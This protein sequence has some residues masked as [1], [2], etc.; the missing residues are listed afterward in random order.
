MPD[1][2]PASSF[3]DAPASSRTENRR[4]E[5]MDPVSFYVSC[6]PL[7]RHHL[8]TGRCGVSPLEGVMEDLARSFDFAQDDTFF[9]SFRMTRFYTEPGLQSGEGVPLIAQ[10]LPPIALLRRIKSFYDY[11]YSRT[12][13]FLLFL[14]RNF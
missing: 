12:E 11:G 5:A 3:L 9:F 8:F 1:S 2:V 14:P 10:T 4:F 7:C 13:R 6:R